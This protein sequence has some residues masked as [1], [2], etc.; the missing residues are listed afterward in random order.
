MVVIP[1]KLLSAGY[2]S[3]IYVLFGNQR[4]ALWVFQ[5]ALHAT[6]TLLV[7][8]ILGRVFPRLPSAI[9]AAYYLLYPA[10]LEFTFNLHKDIFFSF[11]FFL[12]LWAFLRVFR[13][14]KEGPWDW[15]GILG[16]IL[17]GILI[18]LSRPYVYPVLYLLALLVPLLVLLEK[19]TGRCSQGVVAALL[20]LFSL[21][22]MERIFHGVPGRLVQGGEM[23]LVQGG[24]MTL[25]QGGETTLAQGGEMTLAQAEKPRSDG[26]VTRLFRSFQNARQ[27]F[28]STEGR[29]RLDH[30]FVPKDLREFTFYIPRA[31]QIGLFSPWPTEW[32]VPGSS[33]A[34]TIWKKL[35]FVYGPLHYGALGLVLIALV[36]S[37]KKMEIGLIL[38][39]CLSV[40]TFFSM[41]VSNIGA[42]NRFRNPPYLLLVTTGI[43]WASYRLMEARRPAAISKMGPK[44]INEKG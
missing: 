1:R 21:W 29:S 16:I 25:A 19:G 22:S 9:G 5:A 10:S 39:F 30:D 42:L 20:V 27:G 35:L 40:I 4:E 36:K 32:G 3:V 41:I 6:N 31:V 33:T 18:K 13:P 2:A 11:G 28:N 43:A 17:A 15:A 38:L 44:P 26:V 23:T 37:P 34:A 7:F 14:A 8:L 24:E 12:I